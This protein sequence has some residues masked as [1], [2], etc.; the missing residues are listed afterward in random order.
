MSKQLLI[1]RHAHRSTE[2]SRE[3]DNGLSPKGKKQAKFLTRHF[4]ETYGRVA[5]AHVLSSPKRRCWET[6]A[7]LAKYL[8]TE[9]VI[10]ADLDEGFQLEERAQSFLRWWKSEAPPFTVI[11]SHGDWIPYFMELGLKV[12]CELRKGGLIELELAGGNRI[13]PVWIVQ[14]LSK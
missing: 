11:S 4:K 10:S 8:R 12:E 14:E 13:R 2:P 5:G 9:V 6:V 1:I 3:L 7:P